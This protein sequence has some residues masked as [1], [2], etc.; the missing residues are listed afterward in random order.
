MGRSDKEQGPR[1]VRRPPRK[2][3]S[4]DNGLGL[5]SPLLI[6]CSPIRARSDKAKLRE[7]IIKK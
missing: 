4:S 6:N 5:F 1:L 3:I 7:E 2:T